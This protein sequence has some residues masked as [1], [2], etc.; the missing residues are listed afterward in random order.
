MCLVLDGDVARIAYLVALRFNRN[1]AEITI[2][3][4]SVLFPHVCIL[5][6]QC[7]TENPLFI[8]LELDRSIKPQSKE[9]LRIE[10]SEVCSV[11]LII[12][13]TLFAFVAAES[14]NLQ[15]VPGV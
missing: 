6:K 3:M 13:T 4:V 12:K 2:M 5:E 8:N 15:Y 11:W 9:Y 10:G 14:C 1:I 7:F